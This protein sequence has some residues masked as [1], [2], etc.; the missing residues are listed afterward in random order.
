MQPTMFCTARRIA[1]AFSLFL[2]VLTTEAAEWFA[3]PVVSL[4][5]GY[6]D[7]IRLTTVD[8][9]SVWENIL[10][11]SVDFG[12]AKEH[13]GISGNARMAARRYSGGSGS[14]RESSNILDREDYFFTLDG[15]HQK[16][17][18]TFSASFNYSRDSTLDTELEDTGNVV[19]QRAT[20]ER[21]G[22]TPSWTHII[23]EKT[24]AVLSAGYNDVSYT[25]DPGDQDLVNYDSYYAS[26][27]LTRYITE[28]VQGNLSASYSQFNP[29]TGFDST[30]VS[31]QGGLGF[32]IT[33]SLTA[34]FLAGQRETTSE[35]K[36]ASGLC[37]GADP[38]ATFPEC[39]GSPLDPPYII[40]GEVDDEVE[41]SGN[42]YSGDM[43]YTHETG[44]LTAAISRS[45]SPGSQGELLDTTRL[46]LKGTH[47]FT[48]RLKSSINL[49]YNERETVVNRLGR[50]PD[51]GKQELFR[52]RPRISWRWN[53]EWE[54]S[55][56]YEYAENK[57]EFDNTARRNAFY[58][59]LDYR[60]RKFSVA[61]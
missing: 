50:E 12:V 8:H 26:G 39:E 41:T 47:A 29:D 55:G 59:G 27:Q 44:I 34:S 37:I 7:N 51:Q 61:R 1:P 19:E 38:D 40:T 25:D 58:L 9:D 15:F 21:I 31:F 14:G 57:N 48:D 10:T 45:T 22:L 4:K 32:N 60:P 54:I 18:D 24:L 56:E 36:Y 17:L 6:N 52:I 28:R 13:Q 35:T 23:N 46:M 20:R 30:T 53:E 11:P 42:T 3:K 49:E 5:S 43:T 33:E 2:V 16:P